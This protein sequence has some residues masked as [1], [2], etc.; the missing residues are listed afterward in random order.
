MVDLRVGYLFI[1]SVFGNSSCGAMLPRPRTV[2]GRN[3][4]MKDIQY[5]MTYLSEVA[6]SCVIFDQLCYVSCEHS[7]Y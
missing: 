7:H 3:I 4:K 6:V 2:G 1:I 5:P